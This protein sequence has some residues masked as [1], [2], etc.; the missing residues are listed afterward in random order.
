MD[1]TFH[2]GVSDKSRLYEIKTGLKCVYIGIYY[3]RREGLE[4]PTLI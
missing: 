4:I 2:G 3:I 1:H